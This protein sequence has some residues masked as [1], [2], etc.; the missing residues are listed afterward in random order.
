M[1]RIAPVLFLLLGLAACG[2]SDEAATTTGPETTVEASTTENSDTTDTTE[3]GDAAGTTDTT[4]SSDTTAPETTEAGEEPSDD[5]TTT[6]AAYIAS[7]TPSTYDQGLAELAAILGP[8][9]PSG[10][11]DAF[12]T[13]QNPNNDVEAF[14]AAQN[15]I[16]G[17][18]LPICEGRFRS[19]IV[20]EADNAIAADAFVSAVR[21]GDRG[22]AERLAPTNVVVQFDWAG[23]P[24]T[25]ANFEADNSTLSLVLEPTVTVFCQL[26]GGAVEFCAFGE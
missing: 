12:N 2:G 7:I 22:G 3:A 8:D 5:V 21:S 1:Y 19:T 24:E 17:Y 13:L 14:F 15:S 9:A 18:V 4:E 20:P 26:D 25:T 10:I 16:D 11:Q 23:Y 6:C